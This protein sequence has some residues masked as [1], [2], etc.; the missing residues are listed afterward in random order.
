MLFTILLFATATYAACDI[1]ATIDKS[2]TKVYTLSGKDYNITLS[3]LK[4]YSGELSVKFKVN[5]VST[6]DLEVNDKYSFKDLSELIISKITIGSGSVNDSATICFNAGLSG[7]GKGTCSTNSDCDTGNPCAI[8][9]CDGDPLRCRHTLILWCRNDDECCPSKCTP[10]D[11][12]DCEAQ[13][14]CSNDEDC[15]DSST[16]TKDICQGTPKK[17][18]NTEIIECVSEDNYCP[19]DCIFK[20][21]TDRPQCSTDEDCDDNNACTSDICIVGLKKCLN[22]ATNGCNFNEQCIPV[23]T[24]KE[25]QFCERDNTLRQLKQKK[26]FCINNYE[27]LSNLCVRNKCKNPS[28]MNKIA[29]WFKQL[30]S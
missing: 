8:G 30:F 24:R 9:E 20:S 4:N 19:K 23:G 26:E 3:S 22:N 14:E 25:N 29:T 27:C 17:C 10:Q 2:A 11:D 21:D 7:Y 28:F 1:T 6:S 16:A 13:D 18:N 12:N 5:G 15:D